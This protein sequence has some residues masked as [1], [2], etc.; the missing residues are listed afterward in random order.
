MIVGRESGGL[1]F[2]VEHIGLD[3]D[4]Y[5]PKGRDLKL[6]PEVV[7]A[8]EDA[9]EDAEIFVQNSTRTAFSCDELL[10]WFLIQSRSDLARHLPPALLKRGEGQVL[11][12]VP[13]RFKPDTF[14]MLTEEGPQDLAGVKL[15]CKVTVRPAQG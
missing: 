11:L 7:A 2:E 14:H 3:A 5:H 4:F 10:N 9:R 12:T 15:M 1:R 13:I 6:A 8:F